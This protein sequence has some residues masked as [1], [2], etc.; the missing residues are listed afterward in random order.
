MFATLVVL[1]A[2]FGLIL[3]E[4][5]GISSGMQIL[6]VSK[7]L[8]VGVAVLLITYLVLGGS[9]NR[10]EKIFMVMAAAFLTYF[11]AAILAHPQFSAIL[12]GAF[13]PSIHHDPQYIALVVGLIGTTISPYQQV[14]QQSAVVE[15]GVSRR[16]YGP[17][18]WDTY[19][20][21]L[22]SS[23]I[24]I[25][26]IV[27]TAA[28]LHQSGNTNINSAADAAKALEPIAG[29]A[30]G[31][32]FAIGIVGA[33]LMA[34]SIIP[35]STSFA[36]TEAFGLVEGMGLELSRAPVFYGL[37]LFQVIL[38]AGLS[39]VPSIPAFQLLVG[40]QVLN[41]ILFPFILVFMLV[42]ANNH[43]LMGNQKNGRF[44]NLLG[45]GSLVLI[46]LAV[47]AGLLQQIL[48]LFGMHLFQ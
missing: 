40:V 23:I 2:N 42:L 3:G 38:A 36:F 13:V 47:I 34:A 41:G 22:F 24:T 12:H 45:W 28:T 35:I 31:A 7:Y 18:R 14:F 19:V 26:I 43:S 33:S 15:K 10:A 5:I 11:A 29:N 44:D 48:S 27:A 25:F 32:L 8:S 39:L 20:G 17:E 1:I 6:G 21:M 30:A 46:S 4:F 37:F 16:R 9:Y